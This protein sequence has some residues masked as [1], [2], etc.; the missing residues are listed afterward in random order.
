MKLWCSLFHRRYIFGDLRSYPTG[1]ATNDYV[2]QCI[3]CGMI[4]KITLKSNTK[5]VWGL[6]KRR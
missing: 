2:F 1:Y 4:H 6:K 3:K 5:V